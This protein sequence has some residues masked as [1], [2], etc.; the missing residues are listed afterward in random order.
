[1][2]ICTGATLLNRTEAARPAV[3]AATAAPAVIAMTRG[4]H[5]SAADRHRA[6]GTPA[7]LAWQS[8]G[9]ST[10]QHRDRQWLARVP[11]QPI[12]RLPSGSACGL[13]G[14]AD[15]HSPAE[16]HLTKN[17]GIRTDHPEAVAY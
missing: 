1:M 10:Y 9:R 14:H 3:A 15:R 16:D 11:T 12:A 7:M 8:A 4:K 6:V 5:P 17:C 13:I 2:D